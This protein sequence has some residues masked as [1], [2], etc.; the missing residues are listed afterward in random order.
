MTW[1]NGRGSRGKIR[2]LTA[3]LISAALMETD[4]DR[5]WEFVGTLHYRATREVL[6]VSRLLLASD[7][8]DEKAAWADVLGQ[9]GV[10][11]RVYPNECLDICSRCL[12]V[13][14]TSPS[15]IGLYG[16]RSSARPACDPKV[17]APQRPPLRHVAF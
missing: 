3:E 9:L 1:L 12:T 16:P 11:E 13:S 15:W 5:R 8:P 17:G 6:E 14:W 10:P 7:C 4:E 2:A